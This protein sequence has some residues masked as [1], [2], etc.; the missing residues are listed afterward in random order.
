MAMNSSPARI[1]RESID[2]PATQA[3]A[4]SP[5]PGRVPRA[6]ATCA[7]V[8]RISSS[9]DSSYS[10]TERLVVFSTF[11]GLLLS[12]GQQLARPDHL[13]TRAPSSH[14][15]TKRARC[16]TLS[17]HSPARFA[18]L[19]SHVRARRAGP[20]RDRQIQTSCPRESDNSDRKSTRLNSSHLVISYAVFCLKK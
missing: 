11:R 18:A 17:R 15:R 5:V 4:L 3:R 14:L 7:I 2:T 13:E 6:S 8:H 20:L 16:Q 10:S 12:R 19:Q 9:K 1:A